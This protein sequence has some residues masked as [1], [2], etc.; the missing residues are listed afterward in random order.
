MPRTSGIAG[1]LSDPDEVFRANE[2]V[3]D[4]GEYEAT[5]DEHHR[6]RPSGMR[7]RPLFAPAFATASTSDALTASPSLILTV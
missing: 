5:E 4:D 1:V 2:L 7:R 6:R 3:V